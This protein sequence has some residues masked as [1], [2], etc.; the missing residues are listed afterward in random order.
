M[1]KA[2]ILGASSLFELGFVSDPTIS[3]DGSLAAAVITRIIDDEP[4]CYVSRIVLYDVVSTQERASTQGV[5]KDS[6]PRFSPDGTRLAFLSDRGG[7]AQLYLFE[8]GG[9]EAKQ[10]TTLGDGVTEFAWHPDGTRLVLIS[11]G[12]AAPEDK[13]LGRRVE[14]TY[15]K[16]DGVGFR[17]KAVAQLWTFELATHT[18]TLLPTLLTNPSDLTVGPNGTL[19]FVAARTIADEGYYYRNVWRLNPGAT[20]AQ[21]LIEQSDPFIASRPSVSL[22]GAQLAYLAPCLPERIGSPTGLWTVPTTGGEPTLLTNELDCAPL[23]SGD[24]RYGCYANRPVWEDD[25][26][27]LVNGNV[28]GS[29]AVVRVDS[30][31]LVQTPLSEAGRT[32]TAFSAAAG[33]VAFTAET[34]DKPGE[35]F[36]SSEG[37]EVQLSHANHDFCERYEFAS[38]SAEVLLATADGAAQIAYWKLPPTV[39]RA[40]HALVLQVHGGPRTNY[41]YGFSFEFQLLAAQGYT[42]VFGNPRGGSSYGYTFSSSIS[43]HL[44]T[45]DADDVLQIASHALETHSHPTAPIHLTGGSYGGFMTNWLVTQTELFTSAVTQR[46]ITNWLSFFGTSDIGFSWIHV[47]VGGNPW[48]HTEKLWAQSPMKY[49]ASVDTPLL[50]LHAE[51]DHRCPIEQAEQLFTALCVLGKEVAFIR[52]PGEGHE[53]SRSGRPDRRVQRLEA[54]LGWFALHPERPPKEADSA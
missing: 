10:L 51:E 1:S 39:P 17:P 32:V 36:V 28:R 48:E 43:G 34:P 8:L 22:D 3:A 5:H 52:F 20:T 50:I 46:S 24:A 53:L 41:G 44:G 47:E 37:R 45:F 40:D 35:L 7:E 30:I 31:S 29:S 4:P 54:I 14:H 6:F 19:Y 23:V 33:Y 9:G 49:I 13:G 21:I 25:R 26:T 18:L 42:V 2:G 16:E 15:Y 11:R 27:L 12:D 38:I